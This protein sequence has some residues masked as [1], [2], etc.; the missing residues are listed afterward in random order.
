MRRA[1]PHTALNPS[2]DV[3]SATGGARRDLRARAHDV[4]GRGDVAIAHAAT[5][6]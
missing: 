4:V 3:A 6:Y 5:L 1:G 2:F